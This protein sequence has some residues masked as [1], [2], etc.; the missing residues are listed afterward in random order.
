MKKLSLAAALLLFTTA[1]T[2]A[3]AQN[4]AA[5]CKLRATYRSDGSAAYQAGVDAEGKPVAPADV[6]PTARVLGSTIRI[7]LNKVL[8]GQLGLEAKANMGMVEIHDDGRV[9]LNGQDLTPKADEVCA[10]KPEEKAAEKAPEAKKTETTE[11]V[12]AEAAP[13]AAPAP[14]AAPAPATGAPVVEEGK[15]SMPAADAAVVA[16]AT[17]PTD[18]QPVPAQGGDAAPM[19]APPTPPPAPSAFDDHPATATPPAVPVPPPADAG[20]VPPPPAPPM[21]EPQAGDESSKGEKILWR[22]PQ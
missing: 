16:P 20:A 4:A 1:T 5:L 11:A 14:E 2:P 8:A 13:V 21:V 12:K 10:P 3:F 9:T 17:P 15:V 6:S 7:P 22:R 19:Q 18:A